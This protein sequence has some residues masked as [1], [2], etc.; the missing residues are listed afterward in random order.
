M[1]SFD[2][3]PLPRLGEVFF[4]VRGDSRSMRLSWYAD[5]GIAVFSIWQGG[6][7]TGTFRLPMEDLGRMIEILER[8]PQTR[9]GR[10]GGGLVPEGRR[11]ASRPGPAADLEAT[12]F[13]L[14][15]MPDEL[16]YPPPSVLPAASSRPYEPGSYGQPPAPRHSQLASHQQPDYGDRDFPVPGHRGGDSGY[17]PEVTGQHG[18]EDGASG[19]YGQDRFVPPYVQPSDPPYRNDNLAGGPERPGYAGRDA[20]PDERR[21]A[22]PDESEFSDHPRRPSS[23]FDRPDYLLTADPAA[24][25]RHSGGRHAGQPGRPAGPD[26]DEAEAGYGAEDTDY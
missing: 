21:Q 4:D 12:Q 24:T 3:A 15:A 25:G 1:P 22:L 8:G 23:Y 2:A 18:F 20:Y 6:M 10:R 9:S 26:E 11:P 17:Q 14:E 16:P 7:C 5:T 19:G 13:S